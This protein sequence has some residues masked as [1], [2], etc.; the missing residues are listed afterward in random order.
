M[1]MSVYQRLALLTSQWEQKRND[2]ELT[3]A[4]WRDSVVYGALAIAG[5]AGE[6]ANLVKKWLYHQEPIEPDRI[7]DEA[8]D[9]LWHLADFLASMD[10]ESLNDVAQR[11]LE[12][13]SNRWPEGFKYGEKPR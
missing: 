8:G 11:N 1:D 6:L 7:M 13:L 12:K 3:H 9:I 2:H 4:E 10:F 5:E